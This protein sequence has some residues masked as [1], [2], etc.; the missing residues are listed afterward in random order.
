MTTVRHPQPAIRF[1][2]NNNSAVSPYLLFFRNS[3]PENY[4]H[5]SAEQRQQL[6]QCAPERRQLQLS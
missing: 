4:Q 6:A 2:M 5:L 3:G 1:V